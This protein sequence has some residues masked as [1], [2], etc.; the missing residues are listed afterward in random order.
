MKSRRDLLRHPKLGASWEGFAIE[1]VLQSLGDDVEEAFY[2]GVHGQS[3]VDLY[4]P[5]SDQAFEF[6]HSSAPTLTSSM[7][8]ALRN[9]GLKRLT[10]IYPGTRAYPLAEGI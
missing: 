4:L 2:W 10:V 3:E 8:A 5:N 9:L 6:R 7:S 1:A